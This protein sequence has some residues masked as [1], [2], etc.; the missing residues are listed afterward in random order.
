MKRK[1]I[2]ILTVITLIAVLYTTPLTAAKTTAKDA[3]NA[4]A[5]S[6]ETIAQKLKAEPKTAK[7]REGGLIALT[8]DDGPSQFTP[9]LLDA[10]KERNI[11]VTFY[12][13]GERLEE[14]SDTLI[15]EYKE[16]HEIGNHTYD[17]LNMA[18]NDSATDQASLDKTRELAE[19]IIGASLDG[20][21][22][23]P[24]YGSVGS[25]SIN[26]PLIL[27][28]VDTLDWKSR[29]AEAVKEQILRQA[30]DGSIILM[31]DL[32]ESSV[33]GCIA[34]VDELSKEGFEFVTV[35]ELFRRKGETLQNGTSYTNAENNG[36]DLGPVKEKAKTK[37]TEKKDNKKKSAEKDG[38]YP[39]GLIIFCGVVLAVYIAGM[40]RM[41]KNKE[42]PN[43]FQ[44]KDRLNEKTAH[45]HRDSRSSAG[46]DSY[47]S[48]RRRNNNLR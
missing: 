12:V 35:K 48:Q 21:T 42:R 5:K 40:I 6:G 27:W 31:H 10:M 38:E 29:D 32:Y 16:G 11:K 18:K 8:F 22:V 2:A 44:G 30:C 28:S 19:S 9:K 4:A 33:D 47:S 34:A 43:T 25:A 41:L 39:K 24:P 15:R 14:F 20:Q 26:A 37:N 3:I 36:L 1:I 45:H 17:H 13:V 23:R 7:G 46:N